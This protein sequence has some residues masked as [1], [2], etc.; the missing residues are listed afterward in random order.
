MESNTEKQKTLL[1]PSSCTPTPYKPFQ[2]CFSFSTIIRKFVEKTTVIQKT[3]TNNIIRSANHHKKK[4]IKRTKSLTSQTVMYANSASPTTE[5]TTLFSE[6]T[7]YFHQI[8]SLI[9]K[10]YR[11][12]ATSVAR[13]HVSIENPI[14]HAAVQN[15]HNG[16][17]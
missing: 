16:V 14:L 9:Q 6:Q 7:K 15:I 4:H 3:I 17:F 10:N 8:I 12:F 13:E 11:I 2:H 1:K 5:Q